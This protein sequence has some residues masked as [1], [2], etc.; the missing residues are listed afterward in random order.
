VRIVS[1]YLLVQFAASSATVL[2]ALALTVAAAD[3]LLHADD[4][5]KDP[6]AA[7]RRVLLGGLEFLP[8]AVPLACLA[9]VVWSLTR[10]VRNREITAIRCGG[11]PLRRALA[12]I[13]LACVLLAGALGFVEDRLVVPARQ[14]LLELDGGS[15]DP[16]RRPEFRNGRWWFSTGASI[17]SAGAYVADEAALVDVTVFEFDE[18]RRLRR[19]IEARKA[20]HVD[21]S[22]WAFEDATIR[23]FS[24]SP[25][26]RQVAELD[27]DLG[28]SGADLEHALPPVAAISLHKL[29]RRMRE[30][31]SDSR[32]LTSLQAA[33]HARL[34][35]PL[36]ILVCVL[37]A[38][39]FAIGDVERGDSLA[40]ALLWSLGAAALYF[41]AWTLALFAGR[42]G[43]LH[44][45][46]P[47]WGVT[48]GFLAIAAWRYRALQE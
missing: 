45:A 29:Q 3:V 12:P 26:L 24:A 15:E 2:L 23:D 10:A 14:V 31:A 47:L 9:G 16:L 1:R 6:G 7:L 22:S 18:K 39:P 21:G 36:A 17:F 11:I 44:P 8:P 41:L 25:Q 20:I 30:Q 38:I 43:L 28:V 32:A 40:R 42:S 48:V 46:L 34:A 27:L 37:L 19:R 35:Q 33:F 5:G 4:F 13:L